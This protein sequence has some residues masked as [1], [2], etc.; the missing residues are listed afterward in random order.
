MFN[1]NDFN[2]GNQNMDTF[3]YGKDSILRIVH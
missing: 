1:H 3:Y 2:L